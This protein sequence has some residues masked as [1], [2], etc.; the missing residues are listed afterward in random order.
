MCGNSGLCL[1]RLGPA[2]FFRLV[3]DRAE[4]E[5][6]QV[7]QQ[8]LATGLCRCDPLEEAS[9]LISTGV[10]AAELPNVV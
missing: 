7:G 6:G 1:E 5:T 8:M 4:F 9:R 10:S 3:G 2:C